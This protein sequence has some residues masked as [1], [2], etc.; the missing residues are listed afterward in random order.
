MRKSITTLFALL[1][2]V[3]FQVELTGQIRTPAPSPGAEVKQTVGLTD[4]TINYSRP[5]VKGRN[6]FGELVPF[7]EIW[8]TG[9]NAA[10]TIEFS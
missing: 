6:I 7:G 1:L 10:T 5:G 2:M 3:G 8:R 4:V 9:A